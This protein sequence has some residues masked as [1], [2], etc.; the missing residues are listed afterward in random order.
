M[1]IHTQEKQLLEKRTMDTLQLHG[2]FSMF[3]CPQKMFTLQKRSWSDNHNWQGKKK[4]K[5][6][7][8]REKKKRDE[9]TR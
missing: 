3:S 5:V 2:Q 4:I 8:K 6:K 9:V 7:K 1:K